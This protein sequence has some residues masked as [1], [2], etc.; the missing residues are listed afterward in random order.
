M[1]SPLAA[2]SMT[3]LHDIK[4]YSG[5]L[6]DFESGTFLLRVA[7]DAT[8]LALSE[9]LKVLIVEGVLTGSLMGAVSFECALSNVRLRIVNNRR[10]HGMLMW[11]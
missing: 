1:K 3:F 10:S 4:D 5:T 9:T 7:V 2:G 6:C 11:R 8:C